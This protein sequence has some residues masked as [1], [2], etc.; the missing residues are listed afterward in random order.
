M[1]I[2]A[3]AFA[4]RP[5]AGSE[6][7]FGWHYP[8]EFARRGHDVTVVTTERWRVE[9]EEAATGEGASPA[10]RFVFV[11]RRTWPLKIGL[12]WTVGSA[13]QYVIWLWEA[14]R[15]AR[16]LHDRCPFD[17]LHHVTYGSLLGGTFLW[18]VAGR[19]RSAALVL[20]PLGGGQTA[21]RALA[22][23]FGSAW[24]VEMLRSVVVRRLWCLAR[25]AVIA[26]RRAS[27][28]LCT[29]RETAVLARRM[30]ARRIER[31]LDVTIPAGFAP[32]AA[33]E[34]GGREGTL[35]LLWL[36]RIMP[37]KALPLAVMALER[38]QGHLRG[39]GGRGGSGPAEEEGASPKIRLE[40]VGGGV[41]EETE[42]E[43][44]AWLATR[45]GRGSVTMTGPV[46]FGEV[47]AAY[48]RAD[49]F[50]FP[51]LRESTGNQL[52]EAMAYGLPVVCLDHQG[53]RELV[54]D[55]AG[56]RVPVT[57]VEGTVEGL[58]CAIAGLA[59]DPER[60]RRMGA[61]ARAA[62][63]E[64][65]WDAKAETLLRVLENVVAAA[66]TQR[67]GVS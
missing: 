58:A 34:R 33:P 60:R 59:L 63:R 28:V 24:R 62:A 9:I 29:N 2:L 57:D 56:V 13:I 43:F 14:A 7:G 44:R 42:A 53:A 3:E 11:P 12:G 1:R 18:R 50:V 40:I 61:A 65:T 47:G 16:K 66:T 17:V 54:T 38:V 8:L 32:D 20:G 21:P 26:S 35:T 23:V 36:G 55:D 52:L 46:P 25:H 31:V 67:T 64:Y 48:E 4:C 6:T 39:A 15:E 51:S 27:V 22:D 49:I 19:R 10:P 30:G 5:N 45:P 41:D 37:R